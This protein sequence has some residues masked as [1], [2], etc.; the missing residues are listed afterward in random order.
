MSTPEE[1]DARSRRIYTR[2][3]RESTSEGRRARFA[4]DA[5]PPPAS[6]LIRRLFAHNA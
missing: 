6:E 3:G 1:D 2:G 5:Q 4:F